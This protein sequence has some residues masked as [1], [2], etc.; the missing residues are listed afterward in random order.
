MI[1]KP[2]RVNINNMKS[3]LG[4]GLW[5][6]SANKKDSNVK[7]KI[8]SDIEKQIFG[9]KNKLAMRDQLG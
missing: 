7:E 6:Q 4:T 2:I 1:P 5:H 9:K 3:E 8:Y